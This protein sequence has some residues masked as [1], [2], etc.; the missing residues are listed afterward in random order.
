MSTDESDINS[1]VFAEK[2]D[3]DKQ[4]WFKLYAPRG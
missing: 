2:V 3:K 1:V 4:I